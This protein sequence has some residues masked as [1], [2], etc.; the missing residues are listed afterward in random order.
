MKVLSHD[1]DRA[2]GRNASGENTFVPFFASRISADIDAIVLKALRR[3][4]AQRYAS[5]GEFCDDLRRYLVARPVLARR[6]QW[7]YRAQRFAWRNRWPLAA[8][9]I[10]VT[11]ASGF[12]WRTVL[13]EREARVQAATSDRV[14]EFLVSVF[15]ASDSNLNLEARHDLSAHEVLAAGS[16]RID[17]ELG[18]QP[19]IRARLLEAVAG[20]YRHMNDNNKAA[21]LMREAADLNLAPKVDQPLAAA[22]CLEALANL[23]ANG[24]FPAGDAERAARESLAL[25]QRLTAADSQEIAN[26]WM[27]LSLA[28]NRAGNYAAAQASAEKTLAMN[29][30]ARDMRD[31]RVTAAYN[32]LCIMHANRGDFV[33][34]RDACEKSFPIYDDVGEASS[35][36]RAMTTS[37]YGQAL[38]QLFEPQ[39]A[40]QA[41][42]HAIKLS[43]AIQGEQGRFTTV[44]QLRKAAI[45]DDAGRYAEADALLRWVR[46]TQEQLDGKDSGEYANV[47]LEIARRHS[48]L[49]EFDQALALLRPIVAAARV[50]YGPDDP[51]TLV[52]T[53]EL[54]LATLNNGNADA[55]TRDAL[56]A[57][58]SAWAR[59]D[60]AGPLLPPATWFALAKWFAMNG[61]SAHATAQLDRIDALGTTTEVWLRARMHALRATLAT[62]APLAL[63]EHEQAWTLLRDSA[64]ANHP[65]T[66]RRALG[67]AHALRVAGRDGDAAA[68]ESQ[69]RPL[70]ER[71]FPADSA[72][73]R[74]AG[75]VP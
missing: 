13:A 54:A 74:A 17:K 26:A 25:S 72:F 4:P 50:R 51:R 10:L 14:A 75:V 8:A 69:A 55:A 21:S 34:A 6:G 73:R 15:A 20:A 67:Y 43:Q 36:G 35:M 58:D 42:D 11:L 22:R 52:A 33:A 24:E 1:A 5:V 38:A 28:Q 3:E 2:N 60:D 12:T 37:R 61:D 68:I 7:V 9:A 59:K 53:T 16:A 49:G 62:D 56:Q 48:L 44:F 41:T 63:R 64:G 31:T 70:F 66:A 46:A 18:D 27:V 23:L 47:L 29:L 32:N 45:L 57:T 39:A 19:R 30:A 40:M 65:Q 71:A